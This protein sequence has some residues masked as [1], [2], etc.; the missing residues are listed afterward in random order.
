VKLVEELT[1]IMIMM[2]KISMNFD[3]EFTRYLSE[4]FRCLDSEDALT[5]R[6]GCVLQHK[7]PFLDLSDDIII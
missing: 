2:L 6:K 4:T 5:Q 3:D 7:G 1:K